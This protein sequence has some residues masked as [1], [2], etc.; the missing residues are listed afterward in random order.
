MPGDAP[1]AAA[2]A[3]EL[4]A[5]LERVLASPYFASRR[6]GELLRYL[7]GL[8]LS[9]RAESISE[10]GVA[11]DVFGKPDSF[12]PKSE[13]TIRAEMSRLRKGL[14]DYYAADGATDTWRFEFPQRGYVPTW[15]R[16]SPP[17][18]TRSHRT[19]LVILSAAVVLAVAGL[20]AWRI[21]SGASPIRSVAVLPFANLT[22]DPAIDSLADGI[23]ESLTDSLARV[24]SLRVVARTSAFQFR[25]EARDI[26]E[27][28][29]AL[30]AEAVVEGS[31]RRM[32]DRL[33][34]TVQLNRSADG[35]H[36]LSRV[37]EARSA[38]FSTVERQIAVPVLA[39]LRP[40]FHPRDARAP[41]PEAWAL[42]LKAKALRG[43][44]SME[45]FQRAVSLLN[46]AI[47]RDPQYAEAYG[48]LANFYA[49]A[50]VNLHLD[51]A[52]AA[53]MAKSAAQKALALDPS[54]PGAWAAQGLVDAMVFLNW[55][56]GE[57]ELRKALAIAPQDALI[58]QRLSNVLMLDGRFEEALKE[59]VAAEQLEPLMPNPSVTVGLI[60]YME[61]RYESALAKWSQ[62]SLLYP[63]ASM[64]HIYV[65]SALDALG[66]YDRA[67]AEYDLLTGPLRPATEPRYILLLIHTG[68]IA[69]ARSRL[70]RYAA[71][72]DSD[73]FSLACI[74]AALGEKDR[75]FA[76][77]EKAWQSHN[78]WMLK[79]YPLLDPLRSDARFA[80]F[81]HRAHFE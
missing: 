73:P 56:Q 31:V 65:G 59:A 17:A 76:A 81:L 71:S 69:E 66:Q 19:R 53:N 6:R 67:K 58:H 52:S 40:D 78:C 60:L 27:I 48:E 49:V 29:R 15:T 72:S 28:G 37:F 46:E 54:T 45:P 35:F 22:G 13:S 64:V 34:V 61:R 47:R 11:L 36:I 80:N 12:D 9:G 30:N 8:T 38:D 20:I 41:D 23:S 70:D 2:P 51:E 7:V 18:R 43:P 5:C 16:I 33:A 1:T 42:V 44:T 39:V 32:G 75:A 4:R 68:R 21:H 26:R 63:D 74:Y 79:V 50:A 62:V 24:D 77:L 57:E 55:K 3:P 14:A 25:N 10:Y